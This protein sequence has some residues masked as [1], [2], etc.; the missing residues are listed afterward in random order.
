MTCI[1]SAKSVET[2]T[3]NG[4]QSAFQPEIQCLPA[5]AATMA[6]GG[7]FTIAYLSSF[8]GII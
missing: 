6:A 2:G 1:Y 7:K 8:R 5:C 3:I 4:A